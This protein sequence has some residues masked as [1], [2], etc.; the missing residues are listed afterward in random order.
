MSCCQARI[1]WD[2]SLH[3]RSAEILDICWLFRSISST[4]VIFHN[5]QL[6]TFDQNQGVAHFSW[7]YF[8]SLLMGLICA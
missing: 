4:A 5:C 1:P 6:E 2:L 3:F 7:A 8:S